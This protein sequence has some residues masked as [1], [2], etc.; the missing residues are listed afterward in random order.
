MK[1]LKNLKREILKELIFFSIESKDG[2]HIRR[3]LLKENP[4][5]SSELLRKK[6][7]ERSGYE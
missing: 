5:R 1:K 7:L 3:I 4:G 6:F 2:G